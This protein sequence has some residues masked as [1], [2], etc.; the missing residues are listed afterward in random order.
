VTVSSPR[1]EPAAAILRYV[2]RNTVDLIVVGTHG[3]IG[4]GRE[5]LGSVADRVVRGAR[6]PVLVVPAS[7]EGR[8]RRRQRRQPLKGVRLPLPRQRGGIHVPKTAYRR[9]TRTPKAGAE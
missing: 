3:H 8:S 1:G 7:A 4:A 9:K 5:Q 2:R 6:C